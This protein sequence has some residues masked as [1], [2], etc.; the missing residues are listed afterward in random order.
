MKISHSN[1]NS[2]NSAL[3]EELAAVCGL[4]KEMENKKVS[5]V[6]GGRPGIGGGGAKKLEK[7]D[8]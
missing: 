4:K 3:F 1:F 7:Y 6:K 2:S 8:S 5:N